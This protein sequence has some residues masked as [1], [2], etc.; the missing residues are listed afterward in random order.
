MEDKHEKDVENIK[1]LL[2]EH[3]D[4]QKLN[5]E[6]KWNEVNLMFKD[7]PLWTSVEELERLIAFEEFIRSIDKQL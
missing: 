5:V 6:T 1:Y 4:N 7:H 3:Y 2:Q